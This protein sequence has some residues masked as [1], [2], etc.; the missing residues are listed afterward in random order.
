MTLCNK[1][2]I[3]FE[4]FLHYLILVCAINAGVTVGSLGV[5]KFFIFI[6]DEFLVSDFHIWMIK[7]YRY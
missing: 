2:V 4:K 7:K 1:F 6:A 3:K 5:S